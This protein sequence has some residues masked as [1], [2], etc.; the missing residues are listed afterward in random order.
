MEPERVLIGAVLAAAFIV[1]VLLLDLV[2]RGR[3]ER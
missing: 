2:K 1:A 3:G